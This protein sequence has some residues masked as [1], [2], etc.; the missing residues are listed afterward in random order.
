MA[1]GGPYVGGAE[2]PLAPRPKYG[3]DKAAYLRAWRAAN[4]EKVRNDRYQRKYGISLAEFEAM[5]ERQRGQCAICGT[6]PTRRRLNVDHCHATGEV[7]GLLCDVC[8]LVIGQ[9]EDSPEI[10]KRAVEY[11]AKEMDHAGS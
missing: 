7:R 3:D 8:N 6:T 5:N 10:L 2:I 1:R 4:E 9:L 11:L